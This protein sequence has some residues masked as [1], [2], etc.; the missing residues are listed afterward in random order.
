M[1]NLADEFE[2]SARLQAY[3]EFE[4]PICGLCGNHGKIRLVVPVPPCGYAPGFEPPQMDH[5]CICPN[6]RWLKETRG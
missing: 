1:K 6:G 4:V 3:P 5:F 2:I